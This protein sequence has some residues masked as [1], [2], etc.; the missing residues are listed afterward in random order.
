MDEKTRQALLDIVGEENFTENI[1]DLV[2]Y[3]YDASSY[4][5]RPDCALWAIS[6]EQVYL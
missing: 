2:S 4:E 6:T 5:H 3:T 1:I